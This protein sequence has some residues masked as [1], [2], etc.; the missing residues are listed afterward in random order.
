MKIKETFKYKIPKE[1]L[2]RLNNSKTNI[3]KTCKDKKICESI[4][5]Y[6]IKKEL[7]KII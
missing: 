3:C 7:N 2:S 6:D 4:M 5:E 1:C